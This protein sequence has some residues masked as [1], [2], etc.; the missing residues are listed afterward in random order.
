[1]NGRCAK[2][3]HLSQILLPAVFASVCMLLLTTSDARAEST[4]SLTWVK[5]SIGNMYRS[6]MDAYARN[7]YADAVY[8]LQTYYYF[9]AAHNVDS[10]FLINLN[11]AIVFS[12][13]KTRDALDRL[14][15]VE[16]AL[17]QCMRAARSSS[18]SISSGGKAASVP[19]PELPWAPPDF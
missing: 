7:Q 5:S 18:G 9:A 12:L 11:K 3:R 10:G 19:K 2:R 8:Y 1:M 13:D 15:Q 14:P 17:A 16:S 4:R 6:G